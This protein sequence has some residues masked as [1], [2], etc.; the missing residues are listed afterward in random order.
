MRW[1]TVFQIPRASL[2][3]AKF[4]GS[5]QQI[6][7]ILWRTIHEVNNKSNLVVAHGVCGS[8]DKSRQIPVCFW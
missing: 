8:S 3:F 6:F 5:L 4:G 7:L 1:T 2:P